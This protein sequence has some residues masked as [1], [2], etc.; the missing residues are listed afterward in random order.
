MT[1]EV[2][3]PRH[4]AEP[5]Y[6][7]DLRA[8][9]GL[10]ADW[11]W[12]V[13]GA[14]AWGGRTR[15][16]VTVLHGESRPWGL[17]GAAWTGLPVHRHS[18]AAVRGGPWVGGLHVRSPGNQSVPGWWAAGAELPE[19]V[20]CYG[21]GMRRALGRRCLGLLLRQVGEAEAAG[22]GRVRLARPTEPVWRL[23]TE[24]FRDRDDW[25]RGLHKKRRSNLRVI[26]RQIDGDD[27]VDVKVESG[28]APDPAR[29]ADLLRHNEHKYSGTLITPVPQLTGYL[30]RLLG[31]PDVLTSTYTDRR[32]GELLAVGT[33]L[34]HPRWP[35]WRHWSMLPVEAGGLRNLYFHHV[36]SLVEWALATG[37]QGIVLGKGKASVKRSL[38]AEP[39]PQLAVALPIR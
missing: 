2:L 7:R 4:D 24:G 37:K 30:A 12:P 36:G 15:L 26:F 14:Q 17:V 10:R 27:R 33:V 29:V 5:P 28:A 34:D 6:W 18:F 39:L 20:S 35:V 23:R 1:V 21:I 38:G 3:D 31:Q 8:R 9:A 19:I 22:L 13:L 11:A 25:L 32:T 16:L